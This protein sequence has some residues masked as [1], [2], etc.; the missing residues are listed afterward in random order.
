MRLPH[1]AALGLAL[2]L[3]AGAA[4]AQDFPLLSFDQLAGVDEKLALQQKKTPRPGDILFNPGENGGGRAQAV[5]SGQSRPLTPRTQ[6][7]ITAFASTSVGNDRYANLYQREY[8]FKA[9]GRDY[10]LPVQVQVAAYFQRELKAGQPV[11]LYIRNAGGF[12]ASD[13]WDWM[14][15]VE[16]FDTPG[17]PPKGQAPPAG[18]GK[19]GPVIPPGPKTLT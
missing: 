14:F 11:T 3:V 6:A 5:F 18:P 13:S 15:L 2:A 1:I 9:G 10:W 4:L 12:R 19:K 17:A 8:L 7:F 16:E